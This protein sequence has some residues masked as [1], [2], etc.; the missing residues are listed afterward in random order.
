MPTVPGVKAQMGQQYD[1]QRPTP[2]HVLITAAD[3]AQRGQMYEGPTTLGDPRA[4]LK[5]PT[6]GGG[7]GT[8]SSGSKSKR[9]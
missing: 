1:E 7:R 5:L 4:P 9:R 6:P 2:E 3:M 8:R